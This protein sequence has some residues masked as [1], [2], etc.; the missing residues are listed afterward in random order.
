VRKAWNSEAA[1]N[2]LF[3]AAVSHELR[4]PLTAIVGLAAELRHNRDFLLPE[5]VEEFLNLI[6]EQGM[7]MARLVDDLLVSARADHGTLQLHPE[8]VD[9]KS[10]V[11]TAAAGLRFT[12]GEGVPPVFGSCP[13]VWADPLRVRQVFRNLLTNAARYGGP[14][15]WIE[16]GE[17]I[18]S[19]EVAIV[20]NGPGVPVDVESQIF[21]AYRSAHPDAPPESMG[22]GLNLSR[23]LARLMGGDLVYKR[24]ADTTRFEFSLPLFK[25]TAEPSR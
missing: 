21:D 14:K 22:L 18:N 12:M 15:V 2:D 25:A 11:A 3:V 1:R 16:I 24:R 7:E 6:E 10:E 13:P 8:T 23:Q 17:A 4:T 19:A 9:L 5:E 20:D